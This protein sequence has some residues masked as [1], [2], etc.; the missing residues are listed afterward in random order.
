MGPDVQTIDNA[1][2]PVS[3]NFIQ[4]LEGALN[5]NSLGA[6]IG[7]LGQGAEA[8]ITRFVSTGLDRMASGSGVDQGTQQLADALTN[9]SNTNTNRQAADLREGFGAT[10]TRFG[11]SLS[12][13]EALLRGE[14]QQ[15]LDIAIGEL[16]TEAANRETAT[17]GLLLS[18]I[19]EM[20][21]QSQSNLNPFLALTQIGQAPVENVVSPGL[22]D[23]LL[24]GGLQIGGSFARRGQ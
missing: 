7:D 22:G 12:D 10:G 14:A 19:Q 16:L 17:M 20:S 4:Q 2:T 11:S 13:S 21:R 18:A 6:G 15:G 3:G 24:A 1:A 23:Q 5:A 8:A 9:R